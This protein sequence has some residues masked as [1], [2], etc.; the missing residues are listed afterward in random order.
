[1]I[2]M[3]KKPNN[4]LLHIEAIITSI[5][6]GTT[7]VSTKELILHGMVPEQIMLLRFLLAYICIWTISPHKIFSNHWKD[8][9]LFVLLGMSGGSVYFLAE[10]T[11]LKYTQACNVSILISITPLLTAITSSFFYKSEKK[12]KQ[13]L[14][15]AVVALIGVSCVVLNGH[16]VLKLNPIGDVLTLFASFTWVL[17]GLI[18]KKLQINGYSPIFITRK[19]FFYGIITILPVFPI[20]GTNLGLSLLN[21]SVVIGN[22]C[23]LGIIASFLC[24]L[25]W[26][27]VIDKI[28]VVTA[29][30]YLY[31]NPLATFIASSL[32]LRERITSISILGGLMILVGVYLS[33]K[34]KLIRK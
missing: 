19:V 18:L 24:Y 28:G 3:N 30:N 15:G 31:L 33:Q 34:Q 17:Y 5:V 9:L 22:L 29:T 7:F 13:L 27:Y 6:W 8:E 23:F 11:A 16:F 14:A 20:S 21:N 12:G 32:V 2:L 4:I 26:N 1:M 10:N 25:S